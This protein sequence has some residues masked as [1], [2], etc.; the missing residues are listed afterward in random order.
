MKNRFWEHLLIEVEISD[1]ICLRYQWIIKYIKINLRLTNAV[2]KE[3]R[4]SYVGTSK[5]ING[6]VSVQIIC[7]LKIIAIVDVEKKRMVHKIFEN[8]L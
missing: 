5:S 7:N 3:K 6:K 8:C 1:D 2:E 4:L